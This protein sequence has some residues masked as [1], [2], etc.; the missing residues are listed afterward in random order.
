MWKDC[1]NNWSCE[2]NLLSNGFL[3]CPNAEVY[4]VP[5]IISHLPFKGSIIFKM[6]RHWTQDLDDLTWSTYPPEGLGCEAASPSLGK[7]KLE[8][9]TRCIVWYF[10]CIRG[11]VRTSQGNGLV[12]KSIDKTGRTRVAPWAPVFDWSKCACCGSGFPIANLRQGIDQPW[13]NLLNIHETLDW[14]LLVWCLSVVR[15]HP[16][17]ASTWWHIRVWIILIV[18]MT[19]Q[20]V[21][22]QHGGERPLIF[23]IR[24][25]NMKAIQ[26]YNNSSSDT[27]I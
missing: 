22:H 12:K 17:N 20:K 13:L 8:L 2:E 18:W 27:V 19:S 6:N 24:W 10:W 26:Y 5:W 21:G 7:E 16:M 14:Q 9:W 1:I 3:W 4:R 23:I 15:F 25:V 11:L